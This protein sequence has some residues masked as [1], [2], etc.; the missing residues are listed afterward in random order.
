MQRHFFFSLIFF[1]FFSSLSAQFSGNNLMEVQYGKLPSDTVSSFPTIYDRAVLDYQYNKLKVGI[2]IEQFYS[3]YSERNYFAI[4]QARL[5]Y[6]S[7]SLE[8][9]LGNF[10]ETVGRGTVLR[11]FQVQGAILEDLSY[12]SRHY[13]HRDMLG[14]RL[15]FRKN[16]FSLK[17][18]YGKPL[19]NVIPTNQSFEDRRPDNLGALYLDYTIKGHKIGG[20]L[21]QYWNEFDNEL[22]GTINVGGN[23]SNVI[24]YYGEFSAG[25]KD[26]N[27]TDGQGAN[28]HATYLNAN[29][30]WEK[31]GVSAEYKNYKNFLLGAG[32]NEPPALV[33]EHIYRT[34]NRSTHVMQPTNEQGYQ[35]EA[36]VNLNDESLLTFNNAIAINNFGKQFIFQEYFLEYS[37]IINQYHD[38]KVF[39][40]YAQDPFKG[41]SN[42][43]SWGAYAEWRIKKR[44]G[45]KTELEIQNFKR[46]TQE[47]YNY[48]LFVGYSY[49]SKFSGGFIVEASNDPFIIE[50]DY[51]IW[52]GFNAK[53][54]LNR[55][56]TILLFVGQRRGG[57]ACNAGVCY[58]VLDFEGVE[59]RLTSRF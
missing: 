6:R 16:K 27:D 42:R 10:Y 34:L 55:S 21:M 32:F 12:R 37:T 41:E 58:E 30:S 19:N 52:L 26:F 18:F 40:D 43:L 36:Y 39:V 54:K 29:F 4:Q 8:V 28:R 44:S 15:Q 3:P 13:F 5:Q 7:K 22:F 9:N 11:S 35:I 2:T 14:G 25:I 59:L 49:Q 48:A 17:A 33:K 53:Y 47:V 45:I 24:S 57:P 51:K 1:L 56:N 23:I 38:L 20:G 46:E 50:T 31:L